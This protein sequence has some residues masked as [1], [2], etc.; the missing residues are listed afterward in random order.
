MS[1]RV[2]CN[3]MQ[4][5][6][7]R[8]TT[9]RYNWTWQDEEH[10]MAHQYTHLGECWILE[11]TK[12]VTDEGKTRAS[13]SAP[14]HGSIYIYIYMK[15]LVI[16]PSAYAEVWKGYKKGVKELEVLSTSIEHSEGSIIDFI[17][18]YLKSISNLAARTELDTQSPRSGRGVRTL[19]WQYRLRKLGE[20][21]ISRLAKKTRCRVLQVSGRRIKGV[22][23]V[24]QLWK[25]TEI[26]TYKTLEGKSMSGLEKDLASAIP[27]R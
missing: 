22:I 16:V 20:I 1:K 6:W 17:F 19:K 23:A 27:N 14:W 9:V 26:S 8:S 11:D 4:R 10:I 7:G 18:K 24:N 13:Q 21:L 15:C 12:T 3:R 25:R 2:C 5:Q